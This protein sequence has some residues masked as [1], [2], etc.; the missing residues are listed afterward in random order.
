MLTVRV[1]GR[2]GPLAACIDGFRVSEP[3]TAEPGRFQ[4]SAGVAALRGGL[5]GA[6]GVT[7]GVDR[8]E[9]SKHECAGKGQR[10]EQDAHCATSF[11]L[12]RVRWP[13]GDGERGPGPN[14]CTNPAT[15]WRP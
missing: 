5:T 7:S 11:D 4:G 15:T 8:Y 14:A 6:G 12:G 13:P 1:G 3:A 9:C 10:Q 2:R